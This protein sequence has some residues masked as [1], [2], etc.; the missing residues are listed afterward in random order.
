M[1]AV[2]KI[3]NVSIEEWQNNFE[4]ERA[5][6]LDGNIVYKTMPSAQ[7]AAMQSSLAAI[8][9]PHFEWKLRDSSGWWILTEASVAYSMRK[10]GFIHDLAGWKKINH[11]KR[12]SG[13]VIKEK[14]D[15]VCE[16]M[17]SNRKDDLDTKKWVLHEHRVPY[18]WIVDL[19]SELISILKWSEAGYVIIADVKKGDENRI[20]D[21]FVDFEFNLTL[22]WDN[23]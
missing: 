17:S 21:P 13:K 8:L 23:S 22:L 3:T 12:P 7:H 9:K 15:W 11:P 1:S 16:V 14:P 2:S 4:N 6:L 20:I 18:Y 10:S 19:E 5:E